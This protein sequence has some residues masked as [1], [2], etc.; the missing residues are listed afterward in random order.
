[1]AMA[2]HALVVDCGPRSNTIPG[3]GD[4]LV[5]LPP[6]LRLPSMVPAPIGITLVLLSQVELPH[7]I[8]YCGYRALDQILYTFR[9]HERYTKY[10]ER[11]R[12]MHTRKYRAAHTIRRTSCLISF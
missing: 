8:M 12:N 9:R 1:M 7:L 6:T 10:T 2:M 3:Q 4:T 5:V 11:L